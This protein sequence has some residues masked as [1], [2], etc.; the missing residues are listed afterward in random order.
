MEILLNSRTTCYFDGTYLE[1][2]SGIG[3]DA[4]NLLV[5][6]RE[7]FG[8]NLMVI[9][10]NRRKFENVFSK[11]LFKIQTLISPRILYVDLPPNSIYIQSHVLAPVPRGANLLL[12]TRLHDVFPITNPEWFRKI[13]ANRFRQAFD[14]ISQRAF[15]LC[16]SETTMSAAIQL[17]PQASAKYFVAPCPIKPLEEQCCGSCDAC[18]N[19]KAIENFYIS[20]GT[21]EP[22]KNYATLL[23]AW[24][25]F[26][27][28]V[29]S[30]KKSRLVICGRRGW[31]TLKTEF[32]LRKSIKEGRVIWFRS[33]CDGSLLLLIGK[34]KGLISVSL[35]EGFNLPPAEALL[36][37]KKVYLSDIEVHREI[38]KDCAYFLNS[39][40]SIELA[41]ELICI[42]NNVEIKEISLSENINLL[43]YN[44]AIQK[45]KDIILENIGQQYL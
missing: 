7:V 10:P 42:S 30:S 12:F 24:K 26:F 32:I 16:D 22:R 4:R 34:S 17:N 20:I 33:A 45:I 41:K 39:T 36:L 13:S 38:Y 28:A 23:N 35:N 3:R 8:S 29:G 31:K 15:F 40:S 2:K 25:I 9:Y 1:N 11:L 5:A 27:N 43:D 14:E 6:S 44:N 37:K 19:H 18:Q 21:I